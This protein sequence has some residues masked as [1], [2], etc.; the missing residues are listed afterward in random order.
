MLELI[1]IKKR[2]GKS[3]SDVLESVNLCIRDGTIL[4]LAGLN[5]V[6]KTTTIKIASGV[7][8][9]NRGKVLIDGVD[10]FTDRMTA[11]RNVGWIPENENF[12][13]SYRALDLMCYYC[14]IYGFSRNQA[15]TK[16]SELL[17]L[18]GLERSMNQR[19]SKFSFGMKKRFMVAASMIA[20]PGNILLD[21]P[22][23]GLDPEGF[24]FLNRM[25]LNAKKQGKG[26]LVS[27]HILTELSEIADSIAIMHRGRIIRILEKKELLRE[28]SKVIRL[29]L[30]KQ[31][32]R[33][34][35][36]LS[37]F[38][39]VSIQKDMIVIFNPEVDNSGID[40][41]SQK[42]R[43]N[44]YEVAECRISF[45]RL[46]DQFFRIIEEYDKGNINF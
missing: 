30:D 15:L 34:V 35:D 17:R 11:I 9:P 27:S 12:D 23:N 21:E 18:V 3:K 10:L 39:E 5:G 33:V 41:V 1:D 22:F 38:G 44:G 40:R 28:G 36:L 24:R 6:G 26:L 29:R 16:S 8:T 2:Y 31:N 43:E 20:D 19:L 46:E 42:L 4:G 7:L 13:T 14:G 45:E 32:N 37:E 25:I